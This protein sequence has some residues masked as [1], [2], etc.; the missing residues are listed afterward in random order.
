MVISLDATVQLTVIFLRTFFLP[1]P[2]AK[3]FRKL[4]ENFRTAS[5]L[6]Q[7]N[8]IG[9]PVAGNQ[10]LSSLIRFLCV[11]R[12][13]ANEMRINLQVDEQWQNTVMIQMMAKD[14]KVPLDDAALHVG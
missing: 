14:P 2:H 7:T 9:R 11:K 5:G 1:S 10:R 8:F 13:I 12:Y 3:F 4:H 6:L